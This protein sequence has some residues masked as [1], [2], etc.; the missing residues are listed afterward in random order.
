MSDHALVTCLK[1]IA[2]AL[3]DPAV[4]R[5]R[6][7]GPFGS[8]IYRKEQGFIVLSNIPK[9]G[10][11]SA[12]TGTSLRLAAMLFPTSSAK[13]VRIAAA[14]A[15]ISGEMSGISRLES[16]EWPLPAQKRGPVVR[17]GKL[18]S[19]EQTLGESYRV[20]IKVYNNGALPRV[21]TETA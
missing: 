17:S 11:K 19:Y 13:D 14:L 1:A 21:E 15:D 8:T 12:T 9:A 20:L 5:V 4:L 7:A 18:L 16:G 10:R 6:I 3:K 2:A